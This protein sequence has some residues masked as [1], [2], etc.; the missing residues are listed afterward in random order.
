MTKRI[1]FSTVALAVCSVGSVNG[2]DN[3]RA[4]QTKLRDSGFYSGEIDGAYS[5]A[6]S[7]A[8][9]RYQT[10]NGL[11]ITGQLDIDTSKALGAKP[12]VTSDPAQSAETWRRLRHGERQSNSKAGDNDETVTSDEPNQKR[13]KTA[14]VR[15]PS[16]TPLAAE[17]ETKEAAETE[18][19]QSPRPASK[20]VARVPSPA[21]AETQ[22][23]P[24]TERVNSPVP[25]AVAAGRIASEPVKTG[26]LPNLSKARLR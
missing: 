13:P 22:T 10:T 7:D 1:L 12:A 6:L 11:P 17:A 21:Q 18:N 15:N 20:R 16:A 5:G 19:D 3:V 9:T 25:A 14:S 2:D 26:S 24:E 8:L 4:V 23:V